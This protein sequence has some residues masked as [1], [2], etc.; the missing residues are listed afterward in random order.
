M[1]A[2][3]VSSIETAVANGFFQCANRKRG[4]CQ[5]CRG[6]A[7]ATPGVRGRFDNPLLFSYFHQLELPKPSRGPA[8]P[9]HG[10]VRQG[11]R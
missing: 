3:S 2:I 6:P 4:T 5:P 7:Q 10:I 9:G 1:D 11:V 8:L